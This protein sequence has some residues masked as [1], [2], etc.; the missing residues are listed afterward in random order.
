MQS[1]DRAGTAANVRRGV[2][3]L[4]ARLRAER[5]AGA[6]SGNKLTVLAHL[7]RF[8]PSTPGDIAAVGHQQPQSLTRVFA[9]LE[10]GGLVS[11][12]RSRRDGR[13]AVL[14]LEPA[15]RAALG[16]DMAQRDAWLDAALG[17]FTAAEVG[18]LEIAAGLL[19]RLADHPAADAE[20][21]RS[22]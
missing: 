10:L 8:G 1:S 20:R 18:V 3:R 16:A 17:D 5:P 9:E 2:T 7:Y 19:E 14:T 15:G 21:R 11:R 13:Q 6:L 4:A 22:A 12:S